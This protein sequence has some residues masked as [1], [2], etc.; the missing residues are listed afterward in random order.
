MLL[1]RRILEKLFLSL[2]LR[3]GEKKTLLF[4]ILLP[5]SKPPDP[6]SL[7]Y[8]VDRVGKAADDD[9]VVF[10]RDRVIVK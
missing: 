4:E 8:G 2:M 5:P 9:M 10:I 6:N 7:M 3:T 1:W